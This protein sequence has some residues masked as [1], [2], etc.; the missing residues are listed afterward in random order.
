VTLELLGNRTRTHDGAGSF[1]GGRYANDPTAVRHVT[2]VEP[3]PSIADSR[4]G[5]RIVLNGTFT[6]RL[7]VESG[8]VIVVGELGDW[9]QGACTITFDDGCNTTAAKATSG[10]VSEVLLVRWHTPN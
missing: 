7:A 1:A 4:L 10:P 2:H 6:P 5:Y 9:G 3:D 8:S